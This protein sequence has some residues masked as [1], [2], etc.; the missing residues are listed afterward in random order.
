MSHAG[1]VLS[2]ACVGYLAACSKL[3]DAVVSPP[4]RDAAAI[5]LENV[6]D[7]LFV[8]DSTPAWAQVN[9]KDG[10]AAWND[11]VVT[12]RSSNTAVVSFDASHPVT[13]RPQAFTWLY[14][15]SSGQATVTA[16][17]TK[18][19]TSKLVTVIGPKDIAPEDRR[20]GY[21]L[22]NQPS[23]TG[24]YA[25]DPAYVFNSGGGAVAI[26]RDS[27]GWYN[28][29][30]TGLGR[31]TGYRDNVQVTAYA[32]PP[33][34]HCKLLSWP[35][36]GAD[37]VVPVHCHQ[38]GGAAIDSR[39]TVLLSGARV[40]DL[41][42]PFGFAERP[43]QAQNLPLD[44]S[45][46][47]FNSVSGHIILGK[48]GPGV[49]NFAFPGW[50]SFTSPMTFLATG[51]NASS[52]HC[53]VSNYVLGGGPQTACHQ[54]DGTVS[55]GRVTVMAFTRGRV[56]HRYA[57]ASTNNNAAVAP[58]IDATLTFNS[59]GGSVT[60]RRLAMGRWTVTFAGLGRPAGAT[61]IAIV[62]AL[63]ETDH[64]CSLVSWGNTGTAD[65]TVS[66]Q[67][68]DPTGA[69]VDARFAVVVIE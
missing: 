16:Q 34:V 58:T 52:D 18:V 20:L 48:A 14:G 59:S 33:G 19:T 25:P 55:E 27:T 40:Y 37:L 65:L 56:G 67:C 35:T 12:W 66:L 57:Y 5:V 21:A 32:S 17:T 29:R 30:F 68:F 9:T 8:G 42:T 61:E 1:V 63:K 23:V 51:I 50:E 38:A 11:T 44:T 10:K 64:L 2:I 47:A 15:K 13:P 36:D 43:P 7:T 60:S 54:A 26:T 46:T 6:P 62:S 4:N 31:K 53:R 41:T 3:V 39:F 28:V 24:P 22:A 69:F 49:Y 45:A